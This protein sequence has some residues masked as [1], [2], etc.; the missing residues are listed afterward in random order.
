MSTFTVAGGQF[1]LDGEPQLIQA[2][3]FHY[4]RTPRDQWRHRLGLLLAAGFNAVAAYMPWLWHESEQG[5]WDFDGHSHPQ[6][7]LAGFIDLAQAMG[8]YVIA[9]PG[10]YIMAESLHEGLP[11]WLFERY[12]Q[13]VYT[14]VGG[15]RDIVSYL[16]P[17][18]LACVKQWYRA[19]FAVLTPRQVTHGGSIIMVQLDNEMGMLQWVRNLFDVNPDTLAHFAAYLRQTYG[20]QLPARYPAAD[21]PAF[22]GDGLAYPAEPYGA[23][24]AEDYRRFYRDYLRAYTACLLD[25]ARAN[26]LAVPPVVNI[27]GFMN[28]GKTFAIGISQLVKV[29]EMDGMVSATD[30][31]PGAISEGTFHQLLLVNAQTQA[32]QNPEQALF[33][34]EFQAGGNGDFSTGQS[35]LFDLHARLCLSGGM[36]AIN[37]Y[38][39]FDGENH[40]LVSPTKRHDW[41][42]PVRVD[43]TLRS[44][45]PRYGQLSSV[46][47]AYGRALITAQPVIATTIGFQLDDFMTE[48]NNALTQPATRIITHQRE[49]ILFDMLAKGLALTH[50][51]FDALE[52]GR[53]NLQA[54][55]PPVLWVMLEKTCPAA[56]Q[57]KLVDY[58][59]GGGRL[60]VAGRMC[61]E[62]ADHTAC[63]I[64]SDALGIQAI[65]SDAPFTRTY[66]DA[67]GHVDL[68]AQFVETYTGA[69]TEVIATRAGATVGFEQRLGRGRALVFGASVPANTLTDLDVVEQMAQR[70]DCPRLLTLSPWADARLSRG[71]Q[72]SFLFLANYLDDPVDPTVTLA[73]QVL[74]GGHAIHLPARR[75]QILPLDWRVNPAVTVHY[76]TAEVT[77]VQDAGDQLTL[78][79]RLPGFAAELTLEGYHCAGAGP[80]RNGRVAVRGTDGRLVLQRD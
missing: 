66:I 13:A 53:A 44:H 54:A 18:F 34:I 19:I 6:R 38:L 8:L 75:G 32:V 29:M 48:V 64:L 39:F 27:H 68:P 62:A 5:E 79:T 73:G 76:L 36:R 23:P 78:T 65:A 70:M 7:D 17:D 14:E 40:P 71:D 30:V 11:A 37:H 61:T 74:F 15:F 25:E 51:P 58:V 80:S 4:F 10:P 12:P 16:H 60:I 26:G 57:Q 63:L 47:A 55:R 69:F 31:Y 21:L 46:L 50:R 49:E 1:R 33:S 2:G 22:L 45:Y 59:R 9:R 41:G 35:S 43:G 42:H 28:G 56:T 77:A 72:G 20:P 67:L 3:E 24:L 52:L